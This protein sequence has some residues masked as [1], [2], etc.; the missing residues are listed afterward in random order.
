MFAT[1][2]MLV[3]CTKQ[4]PS[5]CDT[6]QDCSDGT[7]CEVS[8]HTC[9][10]GTDTDAA[11]AMPDANLCFGIAPFDVCLLSAP[12]EEVVLPSTFD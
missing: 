3:G 2:V 12:T 1:W 11:V 10:A 8:G 7:H 9:V 4:N 5:Y 6:T